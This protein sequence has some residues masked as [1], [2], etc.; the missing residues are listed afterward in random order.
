[1]Y[2]ISRREVATIKKLLNRRVTDTVKTVEL[3]T[4]TPKFHDV[5]LVYPTRIHFI[6]SLSIKCLV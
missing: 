3:E 5:T 6:V 2:N 1:M 4:F